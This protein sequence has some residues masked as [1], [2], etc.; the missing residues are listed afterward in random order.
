MDAGGF[1][2]IEG[3]LSAGDRSAAE[4]TSISRIHCPIA[5]SHC[6]Q[7]STADCHPSPTAGTKRWVSMSATQDLYGEHAFPLQLAVLIPPPEVDFTGGEFVMTGQRPRM[8]SR[9]AVVPLRHGDGVIFAV[10][11]AVG[12]GRHRRLTMI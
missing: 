9:P 2:I 10:H 12:A 1:E 6:A 11:L 7:T 4:N 8:Q 5:S 3:L